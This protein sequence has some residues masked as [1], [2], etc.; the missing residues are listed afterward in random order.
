MIRALILAALIGVA[1]A[2]WT[3]TRPGAAAISA[4]GDTV[5]VQVLDNGFHTDL[6]MPRAALIR[7]GGPLAHATASLASGDWILIG[8]GDARFY[9]DQ[10]P[11]ADRLP[12]GARAF[13]RPGNASVVML[14]PVSVDPGAGHGGEVARLILTQAQ[15]DRMATRV[16]QSLALYGG[17]PRVVAARPGDDARFFASRE[18]FSIGHLCNHWT[19]GVLNAAGVPIRPVRSITSAEVMRSVRAAERAK[20]PERKLDTRPSRD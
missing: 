15:F 14:D 20:A 5:V 16:E 7:R 11:I 4:V 8:W 13:F 6:A 17:S 2:L 12:D 19:S 3:W 18:T 10:S 9:V 1:A